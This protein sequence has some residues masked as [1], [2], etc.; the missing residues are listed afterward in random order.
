MRVKCSSFTHTAPTQI[1]YPGRSPEEALAEIGMTVEGYACAKIA[2]E[3]T[4]KQG[5]IMPITE[6]VYR[7]LYEGKNLKQAVSDLMGR[8]TCHESEEVWLFSQSE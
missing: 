5:V 7:V 4:Q 3:L 2:W 8:P 6:Q 1:F